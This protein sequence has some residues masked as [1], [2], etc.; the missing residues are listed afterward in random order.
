MEFEHI[1]RYA[2]LVVPAIEETDPGDAGGGT[3]G[4]GGGALAG[5]AGAGP[6]TDVN[7]LGTVTPAVARQIKDACGVHRG[8]FGNQGFKARSLEH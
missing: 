4:D 3:G 7:T 5:G 6:I 8:D 1:R 2:S